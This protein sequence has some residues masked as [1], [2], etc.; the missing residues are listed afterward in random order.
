MY[1]FRLIVYIKGYSKMTVKILIEGEGLNFCDD[2]TFIDALKILAM[3]KGATGNDSELPANLISS[4][5]GSKSIHATNK[6][7]N[8]IELRSS[9]FDDYKATNSSQKI[10]LISA[11]LDQ[12]SQSVTLDTIKDIFIQLGQGVPG[13][14]G[15]EIRAAC[16]NGFLIKGQ[17][18]EHQVTIS[19]KEAIQAKDISTFKKMQLSSSKRKAQ[20]K[21]TKKTSNANNNSTKN[22]SEHVKKIPIKATINGYK[23]YKEVKAIRDQILW[24][25]NYAKLEAINNISYAEIIFISKKLHGKVASN[26]FTSANMKNLQDGYVVKLEDNKFEITPEGIALIKEVA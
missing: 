13:D 26:N 14:L 5:N 23:S 21:S 16:E 18:G 10:A 7:Q 3:A 6:N 17:N 2:I 24:I 8:L 19:C 25:I 1:Y 9:L 4:L 22:V 15:R 12:I 20:K 11:Y